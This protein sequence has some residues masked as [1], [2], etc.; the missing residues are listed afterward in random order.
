MFRNI[1]IAGFVSEKWCSWNSYVGF[2]A[3][4]GYFLAGKCISHFS[5]LFVAMGDFVIWCHVLFLHALICI[6]RAFLPT[7]RSYG[8]N[9]NK[10]IIEFTGVF[11]FLVVI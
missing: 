7:P 4:D 6:C 5:S 10:S 3:T 2:G 1:V 8:G 11:P 9:L